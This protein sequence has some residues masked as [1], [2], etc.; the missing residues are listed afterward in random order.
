MSEPVSEPAVL[1]EKRDRKAYI[2]LNRPQAM[3]AI[4]SELRELLDASLRDAEADND[5]LVIL[6]IGGG[7]RAFCAGMDLKERTQKDAGSGTVRVKREDVLN[8]CKKPVIAAIDGYCVAGGMEVAMRCDI[9]VAT[10][11]STFGMPEPRR[12][13]MSSVALHNL[14]RQ[15]PLGEAMLLH[16]TGRSIS[17]QRAYEIGFIQVLAPDREGMLREMEALAEDILLCA[18]LNVQAIKNIVKTG[19]NLPIEYSWKI[20][21]LIDAEI[22]RTEDRKEGPR[23]FAEKRKP[24]WKM[25]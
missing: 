19:R 5:V 18:P 2:T 24:N 10:A 13:L 23:A 6:L 8:G 7:G 12:G 17:A 1:Y 3:N 9:R 25:R 21:D 15:I 16:L 14:S 4:N 20:G 11:K 22:N